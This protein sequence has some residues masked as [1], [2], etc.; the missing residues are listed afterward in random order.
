MDDPQNLP[1]PKPTRHF[2]LRGFLLGAL[3]CVVIGVGG[4]YGTMVMRGSLLF[5]D[6]STAGAIVLIFATIV[7]FNLA[8]RR[9][10]PG[11]ELN[12]GEL[13][14]VAVMTIVASSLPTMG[15]TAYL[16][17]NITAPYYYHTPENQW[18]EHVHRP[19]NQRGW[20]VPVDW[21]AEGEDRFTAIREFYEGLPRGH[22]ESLRHWLGRIPWHVWTRPLAY[23]GILLAGLY[24]VMV[25]AMVIMRRQWVERERLIFPIAQAPIE[26]IESAD[27]TRPERPIWLKRTM[28]AGFAI[29]FLLGT[30]TAMTRYIDGFPRLFSLVRHIPVFHATQTLQLRVSFPM[31]GFAFLIDRDIAFSIWVFNLLSLAQRGVFATLGIEM[32]ENLSC[33]GASSWPILAHQ[34]MGALVVLVLVGLW[35]GRRHLA[36]VFRKAFTGDPSVDDSDEIL[37]YRSAV[38]L[39]LGGITTMT[40]W[41]CYAGLSPVMAA[42][43]VGAAVVGFVGLTRVV[44]EGGMAVSIVPLIAPTFI[45]SGWGSQML[46]PAGTI[47][48]IMS[49]VWMSDVRTFVMA[50]AAHGLRITQN[51]PGRRRPMFWAIVLAIVIALTASVVTLLIVSYAYGGINL[52]GWFY[53]NGPQRP[54]DYA[55]ELIKEPTAPNWEGWAWTAA[56]GAIMTGLM[57]ARRFWLWWPLHPIGFPIAAVTWTDALWLSVLIAWAVKSSVLKY[58][59]P[60]LF[61]TVRPFFIGLILGQFSV[62]GVWY[63]IDAITGKV[64]N[65]LF[66]I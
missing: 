39:F 16:L 7:V 51:I 24:S 34:G 61:R 13:S 37:S 44:A 5:L 1:E 47:A 65:S 32:D 52:Q 9:V 64:G 43:F 62:C 48:L 17:P 8:L 46:R 28:W 36:D 31:V 42:V 10:W 59:G 53:I 66:W 55:T 56:G 54:F 58:G 41:L 33:Y 38:L 23:W 26:L 6:F 22:D 25:S 57:L 2:T 15:L 3:L 20:M 50:S 63:V 60:R 30:W 19:L 14:T 35:V 27:R 45:V 40:I 29:P 21:S 49:W 18:A 11:A 4:P 12:R